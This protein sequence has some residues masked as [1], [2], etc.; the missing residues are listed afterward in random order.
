MKLISSV[1]ATLI[2]FSVASAQNL[3][4]VQGEIIVMTQEK[5]D[6]NKLAQD[7]NREHGVFAKVEVKELLSAP[8]RSW[9]IG[10]DESAVSMRE[11]LYSAKKNPQVKLA[12]TNKILEERV[13]PNDP[14]F[15]QQWHHANGNDR[16][17]DSPEAWDITTGGLTAL[18]D[19]IVVC[20]IESSGANWQQADIVE[21]HWV[22]NN[23]IPNNGIDDDENGYIDD[24]DG[25]HVVNL[26]DNL[27]TGNHGTQVSSMIGAKG[28]NSTGITG[29]NWDVKIM[30]VQMG[31]VVESRVV[32]SYSYALAM[33]KLYNQTNGEKGAFVV[34]TNSSWGIDGG[35]P[36][37]APIWCAMYDSLGTYGVISC[38]ATANNNVNIDVVGDLPTACPSEYLISV[39]ATDNNDVRTFS[40]YGTTHVD[41]GAPGEDVFLAGNSNYNTTSGTS[42]AT[43]CVA[44]AIAL[45]Y[46]APCTSFIA[47]AYVDP[48]LAAQMMIGYILEGVDPVSNL[49][50]ET[51]TGGRLNV[52][53]SLDLILGSC[54]NSACLA[55]FSAA[56]DHEEGTLNYEFSW[57]AVPDN[58]SFNFRYRALG[59]I[60]WIEI[61]GL[62][63]P[64][65]TITGLSSCT[66]YEYQVQSNCIDTSS[67]WTPVASFISDGCCINPELVNI[68]NVSSNSGTITWASVTAA[69]AYTIALTANG[70]TQ[71]FE[72][73]TG[74]ELT[75]IDLEPCTNY[76]VQVF[77]VCAGIGQTPPTSYEMNTSGCGS[78]TDFEYCDASADSEFE[79]IESVVLGNISNTSGNNQGYAFFEG[80]TTDLNLG[81]TYT[82]TFTPGFDDSEYDEYFIAWIDYDSNGLFE[83]SEIVV[84]SPDG[85]PAPL[86]AD[87]VV[88]ADATLGT[89]RLRIAMSYYGFF[90]G[91][92]P[93]QCGNM[94]YG[95][96]EDY[97]VTIVN[98]SNVTENGEQFLQISP[99]P[100]NDVIR[101]NQPLN[102]LSVY[103]TSGQKVLDQTNMMKREIS[104]TDLPAGIYFIRATDD[105]NVN[106]YNK[107]V[108]AR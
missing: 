39:T 96:F 25:W 49:A 43:P 11:M 45:L 5:G 14:F 16:D 30:Q 104:I 107:F 73:L 19:E 13:I 62:E 70:N 69:T 17:I 58:Q 7:L 66:E 44:G 23:E 101:W 105:R 40:G 46:S 74:N 86:V 12:Q 26:D 77:S 68:T 103:N 27:G 36:S 10:F 4:Y 55:P 60:E 54:S 79:W 95:E 88:P 57:N 37:D 81:E 52:K 35:Q 38:G 29:V 85:S 31:S 102:R 98:S 64:T 42:F 9:L 34:A 33:R 63:N 15:S 20:V 100:A 51:V 72:G 94:D 2:L 91:G 71:F 76:L 59:E 99:N 61:S 78:C 87:F 97:C 93:T 21:N 8:M 6:I 18:G 50:E 3:P 65:I 1:I 82:A 24:Y 48:A 89:T 56:V 92:V 90:G 67:D 80:I 28:D 106:Y 53:S 84:E 75:L 41:L 32:A 47:Q 83:D 22:N 108:V